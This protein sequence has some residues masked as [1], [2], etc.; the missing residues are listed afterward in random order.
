VPL[1]VG[2]DPDDNSKLW[3]IGAAGV[4]AVFLI[5]GL[6]LYLFK[7]KSKKAAEQ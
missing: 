7:F 1:E 3:L 5:I 6:L 2:V 4:F